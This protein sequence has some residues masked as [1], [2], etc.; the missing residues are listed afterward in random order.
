M[1]SAINIKNLS[2]AYPRSEHLALDNFNLEIM[3]GEF[4]VVIGENGSGKSTLCQCL[5][6]IIPHGRGGSMEGKVMVHGMDTQKTSIIELAKVVGIVLEDPETQIFT[7]KVRNEVAFALENLRLPVNEIIERVNWALEG[8]G[9]QKFED[10]HPQDLSGGQK[11]RLAIASVLAMRP[12]VIILDEPTSQ[13]DPSAAKDILNLLVDLQK[14]YCL[15]IVLATHDLEEVAPMAD[16][17]CLL[18]EGKIL[19]CDVPKKLVTDYQLLVNNWVK[20][21]QVVELMSYLNDRGINLKEKP[22]CRNQAENAIISW[23]KKGD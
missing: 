11:Q 8:V 19:S 14:K 5:N 2:Y 15:T 4:L 13:L 3:Q 12:K 20:P 6:G 21:P 17:V 1:Q 10:F 18:K 23:L 22:I 7:T 9:L 16:R